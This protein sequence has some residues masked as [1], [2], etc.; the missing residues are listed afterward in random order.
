MRK[1]NSNPAHQFHYSLGALKRSLDAD[2]ELTSLL[3][4]MFTR[5]MEL[6]RVNSTALVAPYSRLKTRDICSRGSPLV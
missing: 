6:R 5:I 3:F 2:G 1:T 4:P